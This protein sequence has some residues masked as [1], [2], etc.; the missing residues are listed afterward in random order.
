MSTLNRQEALQQFRAA[1]KAG[2][3][4]YRE[5]L[6]RGQTPYP[7]VLEELLRERAVAGRVDLGVLDIPIAQIRGTNTAGRQAAFAAN[8]MPL[9]DQDSEFASKWVS[10]CEAHLG[11]TGITDPIRCFE[12]MGNFYVQE[13]N[14]RVSV[15]KSFQAPT[16][17]AYVTRVLPVWSEDPAVRVYYEFLHFYKQCGL[18]QVHFNRPGDYPKLQAALGF[19][20]DHVWTAQEKSAFLTAYYTFRT[21][22]YKCSAQPP[23]TTAEALLVWL[24]AYSL[25]DLRVFAPA[26]LE[27]SVRAVWPE[28]LA[29]AQGGKIAVQTEP[30]PNGAG[31][32]GRLAGRVLSASPLRVAFVHEAA[33]Q[34]SPWLRAHEQGRQLLTQQLGEAVSV[35]TYL[36]PDY[37]SALDALERAVQDGAQV[38]FTTTVGLIFACR[39]LAP[40]YP[41][42]HFLNCSVDMPYPGVRTYYSRI[43]EAKFLLGALAGA[44]SKN[45]RIGYVADA[46]IF[47]TPAAINAF[48]LGAQL[49]NPRAQIVLRWSCCETAPAAALAAQGLDVICARDLPGSG[50]SADWHGLCLL[51]DGQP[52]CAALP[53]WNWGAFYLRLTRSLLRGGWEELSAA[54]AI[55]YWWGFASDAVD[56]QLADDVP[57]GVRELLRLLRTALIHGEISPFHRPIVD[58]S[59]Q[60]RNTGARWLPPEEILR[61]DWLCSSVCGTIPAFDSLLAMAQPTVRLLGVY[62]DTLAP[63]KRGP[64][65]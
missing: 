39:K 28:L 53:V 48:A 8:F 9:L 23:I 55:N 31:L 61:M 13:G 12:Y 50:E 38:V 10:L 49:T 29:V 43:Y 44:L 41:A 20:A 6:H 60:T 24:H 42:V 26:E 51:Q 62:R 1:Y 58:Q 56:V 14:K 64:L 59:G 11:D 17:R 37:P 22:Y 15:L 4:C 30:A 52:H 18:Y 65:L 21:A 32:L 25:G 40:K 2:Q 45:E 63:E 35:Q 33:P 57:D 34:S 19:D 16:I 27:R 47:G 46:P 5:C 7:Q 36:V 54:K 3:K